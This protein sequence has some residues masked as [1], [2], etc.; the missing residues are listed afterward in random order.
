MKL[1][2]KLTGAF[3]AL[4][5]SKSVLAE[6]T[7]NMTKV[8]T[9]ISNDIWGLHMMVFWVCVGIGVVVFGAMF[10]SIIAHRKSKG[11]KA[12]NFHE[13]TTVECVWTGI[14]VLILIAMAIPASKTLIDIE[15]LDKA[16][17]TIKVTGVRWK[18]Q[19]DYPEEGI[20]F[21]S[22]LAQSS[23]DVI[24]GTP[25]EREAVHK[26]GGYLRDVD[27]RLVV[28]VDTTIRFLITSNDVIHN[29][30]VPAFGLK[31][32][33]N[34]GFINDAWA[35]PNII[36]TYRGQCAELCGKGHGF[37]PIVVDVVSKADYAEWVESM[38]AEKVAELASATQVWTEADLVAKGETVYNA[39]CSGCHQKDGTGIPGVFPAMIGSEVA[40]G[41]AA[42]QLNLVIN[43]VVGRMPSFK[44]LSDSDIAAV[45]TYERRS[46]GNNGSVVQPSDV[47]SA[48]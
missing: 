47:T 23:M 27:K 43:G 46:F 33:A 12:S 14:P 31:Q 7:I 28:P 45:I 2:F 15:V 3:I 11:A 22:N 42:Y 8:V 6:Y 4:L 29:W 17:M 37:M 39:N 18:W 35:K 24:K 25:E 26:D 5:S 36:G 41:P 20:S 16:D 40:N 38:Q 30:W 48:R 9:D 44:A 1:L 13:R 10:Y 19:Y 21:A 32:D 34:P